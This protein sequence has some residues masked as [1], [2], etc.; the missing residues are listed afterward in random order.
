[1]AARVSDEIDVRVRAGIP[2]FTVNTEWWVSSEYLPTKLNP[3]HNP[4]PSLCIHQYK[5]ILSARLSRLLVIWFVFFFVMIATIAEKKILKKSSAI[6]WHMVGY[7]W[8]VVTCGNS[9]APGAW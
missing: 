9:R 7:L 2:A 4:T 1:M 3:K 6:E 8:F 5:G